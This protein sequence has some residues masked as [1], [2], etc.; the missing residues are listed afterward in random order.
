VTLT[1]SQLRQANP[2]WFARG[3]ARFFGDL[4][5]GVLHSKQGAPYLVRRTNAWTDMF[6]GKLTPHY[7][8]NPISH[9]LKILALDDRQF[10]TLDEVKAALKE[11]EAAA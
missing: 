10:A 6:G 3:N 9:N 5:Y 2:R 7:R 8:I 11:S 4:W 1:I